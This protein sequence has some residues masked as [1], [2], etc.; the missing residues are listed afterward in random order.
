MSGFFLICQLIF[1]EKR[2][3]LND[4]NESIYIK[5]QGKQNIIGVRMY[6]D[7]FIWMILLMISIEV[8][9]KR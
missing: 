3:A 7:G 9:S 4:F 2:T 1:I 5:L 8:P 6:V